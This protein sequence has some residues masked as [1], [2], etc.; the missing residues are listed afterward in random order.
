MA[1][2]SREVTMKTTDA[3]KVGLMALL[4]SAC[5]VAGTEEADS[6]TDDLSAQDSERK[7][8][9][10]PVTKASLGALLFA[11]TTLSEPAGQSCATCHD[12][13]HGFSDPR[14]GSTSEGAVKGRFGVR[15]SPSMAY[16]SL[17]P[18]LLPSGDESGYA[19]GMFWDG[20][21]STLE[22]QA[23]GPLLNP[24][25]MNNPDKATIQKKLQRASYA[26]QF[27]TLFG[28]GALDDAEIAVANLAEAIAAYETTGI[29]NRFT[30]KYD[31]FL[32]GK[33]A[34]SKAEKRGLA[35]FEDK[36]AGP[37]T[38]DKP[39]C[40][41]AQCHL[42]KPGADG[43]PPL[44]T[45]FGYDNIGIP[46]NQSNPFYSLPPE[47]NAG[48]PGYVDNG[49]GA[50]VH[51]PRQFAHFKAPSLRNV[52]ITAPYG[53]NGYFTTLK[54]IVHFYNTRDV[55]GAW[56]AP[57]QPFN[58]NTTGLGNLGLTSQEEDDIVSFL[59]TLTDGYRVP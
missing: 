59:G 6:S 36:K 19:G 46:R 28:A 5:S 10:A 16:A 56:P 9:S 11:D 57:E 25:E 24:L 14:P 37:C 29:P 22:A 51:N 44:F 42:D 30:S 48:G 38:G 15:N 4:V 52:A 54:S 1:G 41:C 12:P 45:D 2:Q 26:G 18:E 47:L 7:R 20:R 49:L 34:L 27:A 32:A 40:G 35:L 8:P 21:V 53:H 58:M 23:V 55:R 33:A 13:R 17:A 3:F 50:V 43:A 31:A 39:P